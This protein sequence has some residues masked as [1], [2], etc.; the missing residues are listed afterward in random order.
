MRKGV[1][2]DM[3]FFKN[4]E[5]THISTHVTKLRTP[6]IT[7]RFL[8]G[9]MGGVVSSRARYVVSFEAFIKSA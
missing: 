7:R 1:K 4:T 5:M 2:D 8:G 6:D 9:V 3:A